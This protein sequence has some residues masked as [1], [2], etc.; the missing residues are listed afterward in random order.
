VFE[1]FTDGA[2]Q[3]VVR[4]QREARDLG[5]NYV[6]TEHLLL[7]LLGDGG[8]VAASVLAGAGVTAEAVR[9]HVV[10]I[11][12]RGAFCGSDADALRAIG[13]DL[14]TVRAKVEESFGPGALD[15]VDRRR[16]RRS[17]RCGGP[18]GPGEIPFTPRSKKVLELALR[19][20]LKLR[21]SHVG[22]EHVLLGLVAEGEGL[23]AEVLV[24]LGASPLEVRQRVLAALGKVA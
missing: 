5:H 7:G 15:L 9:A 18:G 20:A 17:R 14:D 16:G 1:R 19:Q 2:R 11:V 23:A 8:G 12:G 4:A 13:I 10:R 21:H 24:A 6:G 3:V 22:S